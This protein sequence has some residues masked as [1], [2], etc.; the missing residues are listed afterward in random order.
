[1]P[2][3]GNV[4][5]GRVI[6]CA[7]A[8][9]LATDSHLLQDPQSQAAWNDAIQASALVQLHMLFIFCQLCDLAVE[10]SAV[11]DH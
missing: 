4:T 10:F 11:C 8:I 3:A 2:G 1:M 9:K 7:V 5:A 6:F